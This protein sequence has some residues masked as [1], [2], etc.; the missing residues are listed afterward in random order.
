MV[1]LIGTNGNDSLVGTNSAD[2]LLGLAGN[3][4]LDAGL[5]SDSVN[6]GAGNDLLVVDYST[7][8]TNITQFSTSIS[9]TGNSTRYS[10]IERFR[11]TGGTGDDRLNGGVF[12]DTLNGE[13]GNDTLD[14][15]F[16]NDRIRGGSGDDVIT[17]GGGVD[18]LDGGAN[19]D[20][21]V[22]ADL[23]L[24]SGNLVLNINGST[25]NDLTLADGTEIRNFEFF[26]NITSG[27]GNDQI[28]FTSATPANNNVNGGA[29]NDTLNA[30]LG[31]DSVDGGAGNDLLV[32]NYSSLGSNISQSTTFI[33]TSGNITR[34]SNIERFRIT[35][36]S[37]NDNLFGGVFNDTLNG[38]AGNDTLNGGFGN[39]IING[40]DADDLVIGSEGNDTL[41]G[42]T[43][44]D[45]FRY[46]DTADGVDLIQDFSITDDIIEV[47][48]SGFR[49]GL[50]RGS[51]ILSNQFVLGTAAT[52]S[53][54]R[55]IYDVSE[56][57]LFFDPDGNGTA[58]QELL[59][60]FN[61]SPALTANN[62]EVF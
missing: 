9:T 8:G 1:D 17:G 33:N 10:N 58:P 11:T 47:S 32:V 62:I 61:N 7:L 23:S 49:G 22:D 56:S 27:S 16:G 44:N 24:F 42:G 52:T 30:G 39:D 59:T 29:G 12:N 46:D 6:G 28:V 48:A 40:G 57:E 55:F 35:G 26:T 13:A 37:A 38:N 36:G 54:H 45:I 34:Y 51:A 20:T 25:I 31:S 43:G 3:D 4:I 19:S 14:G 53:D 41:T 60:T 21:L 2:E 18:T 5:G 15:G 50:T